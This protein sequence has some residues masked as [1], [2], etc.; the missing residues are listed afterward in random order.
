MK[1]ANIVI[2][3]IVMM[4]VVS[5]TY[6]TAQ[7]IQG[8]KVIYEQII[9]YN[10][11][12]AYDDPRWDAYIADL[13]KTGKS[14]HILTFTMSQALYEEDLSQKPVMSQQLRGA[15]MKANYS[16][17]PKP[18]VKKIF[19]DLEKKDRIEQTAFMTRFFLVET[20]IQQQ[21][22]K[23]NNKKKKVLDYIC[24]GADLKVGEETIT[25]W[26]TPEIPIAVGPEHYYG[27]PG[28]ILGLEKNGEVFMLAIS[29]DLTPPEQNTLN[30]LDKGQKLSPEKFDRIVEEK[31][32][33]YQKMMESKRKDKSKG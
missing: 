33:E 18:E 10:L 22:W 3:V 20:A 15:I 24:L 2:P 28:L 5:S 9:D 1:N 14:T 19:Y 26:F 31:S 12:G 21:A 30:S 16:K 4:L 23:L 7:T 13:P 27:L 32:K 25:A 6:L 11:E 29:I 8:G 17:T